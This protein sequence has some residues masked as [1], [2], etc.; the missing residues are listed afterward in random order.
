MIRL[1]R[2]AT[3]TAQADRRAA[4]AL[5]WECVA[6]QR[7]LTVLG[8]SGTRCPRFC[9]IDRLFWMCKSSWWPAWHEALIAT[10]HETAVRIMMMCGNRAPKRAVNPN[11]S[12]A[13]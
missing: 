1:Y 4:R 12:C 6:L 7:Q 5:V 2:N 8:R 10:R 3:E 9:P 11:P 13:P